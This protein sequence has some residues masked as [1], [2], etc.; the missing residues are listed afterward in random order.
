[1]KSFQAKL[2]ILAIVPLVLVASAITYVTLSQAR[3][4]SE[5][6]IRIFEEHLLAHKRRELQNYV[7]LAMT[8]ISQ[9]VADSELNERQALEQVKDILHYMTFGDDG[10]FF[11]YD[12]DG[13][14]LVH[15]IQPELEG[16]MLI[17]LKDE[18]GNPVISSLLKIASE[19]GGYYQY[20]WKK[21]SLGKAEDKLS[22]VIE[23]PRW[24]WMMGT[25]LYIDDI[26][27]EIAKVRRE[28]N[29][30]IRNTFFTVLAILS[31]AVIV[32]V[33]I[34]VAI[35]VQQARLADD[36]LRKLAQ[37]SV[38]TQVGHRRQIARELHDGINQLMVSAKFRIELAINKIRKEDSSSVDDLEKATKVMNQAIQEVRR[39]SHDLRPSILDDLGLTPALRNLLDEFHQRT[40]IKVKLHLG[41]PPERL[42]E[43][44]EITLYRVVQEALT[45][46]E[47][48]AG[49][50]EIDLR[51]WSRGKALWLDL[52]DNGEGF[53]L[54]KGHPG[55]GLRN[56]RER[57]ELLSGQFKLDS[58]PGK[59][60]RI[61]I[62]LEGKI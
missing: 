25:G 44:I 48:Y 13:T 18:K 35:N 47:K 41:L 4:L 49:A 56:M 28:V 22:Y 10:Y 14:N 20:V 29:R 40:D 27:N 45:N 34:G 31:A 24:N 62:A 53:N 11:L 19:G 59:G 3:Q 54:K 6:E 26:A 36:K 57:V 60:T 32:M 17:D 15:P 9:I 58:A 7:G 39:I 1:M 51:I 16:Q 50:T 33:L 43:D 55:I 8:S 38:R 61:R 23:V 52:Y 37:R 2:L 5:Q 21:P 42:A 30:N 46:I 12:S